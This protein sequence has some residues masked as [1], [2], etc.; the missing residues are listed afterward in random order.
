M[1]DDAAFLAAIKAAPDDDTTRLVFA[2]WLDEHSRRGGEFIRAECDLAATP[3]DI[4]QWHEAFARYRRAGEG[5]SEQWRG[6]IGRH[7]LARWLGTSAVSAWARLEGWCR[8]HHPRLLDDLNPGASADE[9][10]AVERAIAQLLPPDVRISFAIHNGGR[11]S[12][13]LGDDL[14]STQSLATAWEMWTEVEDYNEE[15]RDRHTSFPEGAVALDYTNSG[16]IPLTRDAGH[17]Y[18]G[19]DLAPGPLGTVGQVIIFGRDEDCK[20]VLASGWAEFLADYATFLESG[21][22][23]GF[24]PDSSDPS[25]WLS[26]AINGH[27]HDVLR[28][29]R[30][31]GRWP[32]RPTEGT[33]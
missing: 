5:L 6:A 19:V 7:T 30:R 11:G 2:D 4:P 18:I 26:N 20:C 32:L 1:S 21:A 9:I 13:V 12:F 23:T 16:W 25:A 31:E 3:L 14:L 28:K 29:W 10:K 8:R 22:V 33:S 27:C 15:F 17:N 24:D